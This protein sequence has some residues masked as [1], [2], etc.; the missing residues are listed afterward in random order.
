MKI[1]TLTLNIILIPSYMLVWRGKGYLVPLIIF[2]SS[3]LFQLG[4][5]A[6]YN[7][8]NYYTTHSIPL[9]SALL[10]AGAILWQIGNRSHET[11]GPLETKTLE[12]KFMV[13]RND[14]FFWIPLKYWGPICLLLS[15]AAVI[16]GKW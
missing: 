1:A 14:S 16:F 13:S 3:L 11:Q 4:F 7:D 15:L 5:D 10:I 9:A 6:I 8:P 2:V 12:K